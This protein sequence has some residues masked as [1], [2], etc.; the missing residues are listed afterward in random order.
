MNR[1]IT[2]LSAIEAIEQRR[3]VKRYDPTHKLSE[4]EIRLLIHLAALAPTSFNIQPTRFVVVTDPA[5]KEELAKAAYGQPQVTESSA[6][7]VIT[8]DKNA[9][10]NAA[11]YWPDAPAE[12]KLGIVTSISGAYED[13]PQRQRD[14]AI[15]SGG[16]AAATLMLAVKAIGY[17]SCPMKGFD[18]DAVGKLVKLPENHIV[19]MMVAIGKKAA[20]PHP[21][22]G[23]LPLEE[24]LIR[25]HF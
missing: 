16:L 20:E 14:E 2:T 7:V 23:L 25:E 18:F 1:N 10:M 4:A 21:R 13:Q 17:D 22:S 11:R 3:S 19:V 24:V 15:L 5:L 6:M 9:Y 12:A 8:G